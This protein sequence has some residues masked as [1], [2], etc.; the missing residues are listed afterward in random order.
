M[1]KFYA[2][3]NQF[4][5][6]KIYFYTALHNAKL[7]KDPT[8]ITYTTENVANLFN[9]TNR[10]DSALVYYNECIALCSADNNY[11]KLVNTYHNMGELYWFE[12]NLDS[13]EKYFNLSYDFSTKYNGKVDKIV[14]LEGLIKFYDDKLDFKKSNQY[15][16]KI[17]DLKDSVFHQDLAN[18]I[19]NIKKNYQIKLT[20]EQ[21]DK[22]K[23]QLSRKNTIRNAAIVFA[24]LLGFLAFYQTIIFKQKKKL[25]LKEK[26]TQNTKIDMLLQ[27]KELKNMD[28]MLEGR[29]NEQKRI[30]RDLHDRLGSILSTV[31]LHFSAMD[32]KIDA[33]KTENKV[34]FEKASMLLDEAVSEVR[35]IAHDLSS[36]IIVKQGLIP[37]IEDLKNTLESTNTININIYPKGINERNS[38]DFEIAVYRIIQ[39]LISNVLKHANASK[40]DIY[41]TQNKQ[42][43]TLIFEDN[44]IGFNLNQIT[45]TGIGIANI[46]QRVEKLGG[47]ITFDSKPNTGTTVIVEIEKDETPL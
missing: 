16:H 24:L 37:A 29:E 11:A 36:G 38:I 19:A 45:Q 47:S 6:A 12:N 44:G 25:L 1:G 21:N 26:E 10:T 30:G 18:N 2:K 28:A 15:L 7:L 35:K 8:H 22:L 4:D 40:I 32:M 3:A 46:K 41:I 5:S 20:N 14:A 31:K 33:L 42:N 23:A 9:A 43:F 17:S 13:A 39:E 34:Q 27:E